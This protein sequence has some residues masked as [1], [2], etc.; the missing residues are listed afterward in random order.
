MGRNL[1]ALDRELQMNLAGICHSDATGMTP[2][3]KLCSVTGRI[4]DPDTGTPVDIF[5]T[6]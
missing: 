2:Y 5:A 6:K 4:W 1:P 3:Q